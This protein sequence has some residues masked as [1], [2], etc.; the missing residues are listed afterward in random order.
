MYVLNEA[1]WSIKYQHYGRGNA[2]TVGC[3]AAFHLV[4]IVL[5]AHASPRRIQNLN[6]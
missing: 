2:D 6:K 3:Q 1:L 5:L 4:S